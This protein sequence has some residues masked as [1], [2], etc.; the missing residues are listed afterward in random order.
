MS[1]VIK[2]L[3]IPLAMVVVGLLTWQAMVLGIDGAL[4]MTALVVIGGLGGYEVKTLVEKKRSITP[5]KEDD[6]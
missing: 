6:K 1:E 2:A 5:S 4:F 3:S